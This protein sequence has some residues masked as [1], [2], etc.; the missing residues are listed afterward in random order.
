MVIDP[1]QRYGAVIRTT[2]G[3]LTVELYADKAPVAVNNFVVLVNLGF[4]DQTPI[5]L[6]RPDD[7]IIIGV[8]DNNPLNDAGYKLAAEVGT[9]IEAGIGALTYIPYERL[10]DG[11]IM[12]S[13]SQL[14]IA[15]I[16]PPAEANNTF[17]FF[18]QVTDGLELLNELTTE[19]VI[20]SITITTSDAAAE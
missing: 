3:D 16:D 12:S 5:T 14:L 4:Y 8:P 11:T 17:S 1:A 18:G 13:S 19:D 20:E 10:A 2:K 9:D 7:S 15:L 6:V